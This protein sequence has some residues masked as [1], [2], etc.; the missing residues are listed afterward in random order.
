MQQKMRLYELAKELGVSSKE[1]LDRLTSYGVMNLK[2][3]SALDDPVVARARSLYKKED[4]KKSAPSPTVTT[5]PRPGGTDRPS[6]SPPA[7]SGRPE[8]APGKRTRRRRRGA[9]AAEQCPAPRKCPAGDAF[10][11]RAART[12]IGA[13]ATPQPSLFEWV[14]TS[15][16]TSRRTATGKRDTTSGI[17]CS[18]DRSSGGH[19]RRFIRD[20]VDFE[21]GNA[22]R[23]GDRAVD[24][25]RPDPCPAACELFISG[26]SAG[27]F[28]DPA[29]GKCQSGDGNAFNRGRWAAQ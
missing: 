14:A 10:S 15:A 3:F 6:G 13:R 22:V 19:F 2:N 23:R 11:G 28:G 1:L 29:G 21:R 16:R 4:P 5:S 17:R 9:H 12:K 26:A 8:L 25:E 27:Q 7:P 24:P 20:A 18:T